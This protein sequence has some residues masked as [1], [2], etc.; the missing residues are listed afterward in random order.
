MIFFFLLSTNNQRISCFHKSNYTCLCYFYRMCFIQCWLIGN[1]FW[2][3]SRFDWFLWISRSTLLNTLT[4]CTN[5][6]L[7]NLSLIKL[8]SACV[9]QNTAAKTA[10][11]ACALLSKSTLSDQIVQRPSSLIISFE[12]VIK[13]FLVWN[14]YFTFF[15]PVV[16][17]TFYKSA[18]KSNCMLLPC[19]LRVSEWI[20]TL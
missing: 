10:S 18:I 15:L 11:D 8:Y 17:C 13:P 9:K 6:L 19:H 16:D 3:V 5:Q 12:Q 14:I 20:Y 1:Q 4:V 2:K 7:Y